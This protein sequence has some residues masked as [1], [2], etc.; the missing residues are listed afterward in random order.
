MEILPTRHRREQNRKPG[1][2]A[3]LCYTIISLL[4]VPGPSFLSAIS[5][6]SR[7]EAQDQI[8]L[9]RGILQ[10]MPDRM[11]LQHLD[12][13][14]SRR[15]YFARAPSTDLSVIDYAYR[16][17]EGE[18]FLQEMQILRD[19][20]DPEASYHRSLM[21]HTTFDIPGKQIYQVLLRH[22]VPMEGEPVRL[23]LW[24]HAQNQ[25]HSLSAL[26][27][28]PRG[29]PVEVPLAALTWKGWKR[30]TVNM[31]ARH[32]RT[33]RDRRI[34]AGGKFR[35][36][37]IRSHPLEEQGPIAIMIDNLIVL[38]DMQK[39]KYPGAEIRDTWGE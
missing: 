2:G 31:P 8:R 18:E 9:L 23:S 5:P 38:K 19:H 25:K 29:K 6:E 37:V 14:E 1:K 22:P 11:E 4:T 32:F 27:L 35:G 34:R 7:Q 15:D 28:D 33:G 30:I 13:F 16:S 36:F 24:V 17:P 10:E 39:I 3:I 20:T 12:L 26:F 21:I